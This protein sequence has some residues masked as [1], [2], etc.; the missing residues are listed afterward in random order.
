MTR[1]KRFHEIA[2][3]PVAYAREWK[4]ERNNPV[5]GVLCSYAP[6]EIILA[7]G[8]LGF[9]LFGSNVEISRADFHMQAYSCSLVRG[10]LEDGLAGRLSFLDGIVFPHTCDSIQRLSDIWRMNIDSCF[11]LDMVLPVKLNTESSR[12]YMVDVTRKFRKELEQ[13]LDRQISDEDLA[14][15]IDTCNQ[16]R[17]T[18]REIYTLRQQNPGVLGAEDLNAVV[19]AGMVMDRFDFLALIRELFDELSTSEARA[20]STG[21]R[22]VISGGL[23]NM[24]DIFHSIENAGASVVMDDLCTGSR[25]FEGIIEGGDDPIVSIANRY[26]DRNVCPAKHS[27]NRTRGEHLVKIAK[28]SSADGVLFI[29]LKFCDPHGFDYPYIK[30]MLE[31]N[32]IPCMLYEIEDQTA[33]AG[34]FETRCEAFIEML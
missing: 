13:A 32:G 9:R 17:E 7:A 4:S 8:A 11:H 23:C 1:F 16:I 27:G 30:A 3:D 12:D 33:G 24:P 18:M 20:E 19:K 21:K 2:N 22:I 31:E 26:A 5:V 28:E 29:Y 10:A 25:F 14:R 15:A 34:Q 6:E